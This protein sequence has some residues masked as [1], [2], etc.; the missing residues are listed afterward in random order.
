M[1]KDSLYAPAEVSRWQSLALGI[2]AVF[3]IACLIGG[4]FNPEQ[5]LRSWLLGFTY[6]GGISIGSLGIL[7]LQY[8]T[9]GAW[10][11]VIR[12]I[13]EAG[14]RTIW[15]VAL[16]FLPI[17]AGI[18]KIYPW[19]SASKAELGHRFIYLNPMSFGVRAV[20]YFAI[21]FVMAYLLNKWSAQQDESTNPEEA[22]GFLGKATAFSGP[23]MVI[24]ALV[25]TFA[26]I[27]WVMTLDKNWYST[28][29]GLLYLIGWALS[30]FSFIIALLANLMDKAPLNRIIGK[31]HFHD[32]GKL[33]LALVMVWTYFNLSQF[34]IIY[35]GNLPEE[36][37]WYLNRM[38]N[39]W[40]Y[41]GLLLIV[42][43]FAVP[44][45]LLL[46][47]DIK[48][49]AKWLST[50]AIF[51]LVM[52]LIDMYYHIGPQPFVGQAQ[53]GFNPSWMDLAAP[54]AVGG[55]WLW[56]FF[57]ELKKRPLIPHQDPFVEN[58]IKHGQGH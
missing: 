49:N 26:S 37:P 28:I 41:V 40:Q 56:Y 43:H 12:R 4:Y 9:G 13:V 53:T 38:R 8:L 33:M 18:V 23:T 45:L 35:S 20:I 55:L 5:G 46:S 15:F 32:I 1:T 57:N 11:V 52:R 31:K 16:L 17:I 50:I 21:W 25:V 34:L 22:A 44:Y 54:I 19:A 29:W 58:A 47:R 2:G 51:I 36:T 14:S 48:R 6:W 30:T 3:T 7:I 24:F 42:F 39:G 10:G 27:D